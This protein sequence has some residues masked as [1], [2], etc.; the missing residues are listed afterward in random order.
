VRAEG[1][2]EVWLM[3]LLQASQESVHCII[4]QAF[5][6][7]N[8]STFDFLEFLGRFQAQVS[9]LL[10]CCIRLDMTNR[11]K[12]TRLTNNF[13]KSNRLT[14]Y[15]RLIVYV[16]KLK[17]LKKV[18]DFPYYGKYALKTVKCIKVCSCMLGHRGQ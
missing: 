15:R 9:L 13:C 1:S 8:D 4:R 7:I 6:F 11:L 2:V 16:E 10:D 14:V 17:S 18:S 3:S 12:L 5:H